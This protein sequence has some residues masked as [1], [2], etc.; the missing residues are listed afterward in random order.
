MM[1]KEEMDQITDANI[2]RTKQIAKIVPSRLR[3]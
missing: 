3:C 2:D 1:H